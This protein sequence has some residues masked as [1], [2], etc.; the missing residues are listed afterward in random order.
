ME[1]ECLQGLERDVSFSSRGQGRRRE[2]QAME[3]GAKL[4]S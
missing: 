3:A 4:G 1:P 2:E